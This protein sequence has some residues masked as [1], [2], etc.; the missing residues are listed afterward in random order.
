[1]KQIERTFLEIMKRFFEPVQL[2]KIMYVKYIFVAFISWI[3]WII[4][5]FF[6]ERVTFY[7]QNSDISWFN[8]VL[9]YYIT[10]IIAYETINYSIKKWWWVETIPFWTYDMYKKYLNKYLILDNNKIETIWTW[11]LIWI[12]QIW[13]RQWVEILGRFIEQGIPLLITL[14]FTIYMIIKVDLIY[15][16]AFLFLL[17]LF[18]ITSV[19]FNYKLRPFRKK[20]YEFRNIRLKS[21]VKILMNKQEIMQS[22]KINKETDKIYDVC[23][24]LSELNKDMWRNRQF[25]KRTAPFW[26]SL[27]LVFTFWYL[28]NKVLVWE[29]SLNVIVWLTWIFI[30]M[31]RA[32]SDFVSFYVQVTKDFVDVEKL[33]DF[34]DSTPRMKWYNTGE[35]FEYKKWKIEIENLNYE[36]VKNNPIFKNFNLKLKGWKVTAL[37][38]NSWSWKSTLVKLIAG[39]IKS[40]S[41]D[42]IVDGQKLNKVKLKSYYKNIWYLTQEPSVFD[43]TILDNL[44]YAVNRKLKQ[45]ELEKVLKQ[46]KCEFVYDLSDW[47]ETEIWERW[48]RLSWWQRQRLAIAKI[49]LKNPKIIILDEPTSALDSFSEEQITS[50]MHNLFKDRTVIIIAHRLQTVKDADDI[51]LLENWEIKERWNHKK[52]VELDGQYKKMLDL[53]SGF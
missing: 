37:V 19:Y 34:F 1:M 49:F 45:W 40:N 3:N 18:F 4:H 53:Q 30:I 25:L 20:R 9:K 41:W 31:Q 38:G 5:I 39:Y 28:W 33:W 21:V 10:F 52:L 7:L 42:I 29:I 14:I 51:I 26:M 16:F 32:I 15:S 12:C 47:V 48:I 2:R 50:A 43:G 22:D 27:I 13:V 8:N 44:T 6:L 24:G 11:K 17:I 36:Y 46:A 35:N 23:V